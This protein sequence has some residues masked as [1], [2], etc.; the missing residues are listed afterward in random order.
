MRHPDN[1]MREG[2][3]AAISVY[4]LPSERLKDFDVSSRRKTGSKSE[5][6]REQ[7]REQGTK[8]GTDEWRP[9]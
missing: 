6:N 2:F 8:Y 1:R 9:E 3:V 4:S 7:N 5:Q